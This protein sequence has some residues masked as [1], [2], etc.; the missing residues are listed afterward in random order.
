MKVTDQSRVF[1]PTGVMVA[2]GHVHAPIPPP[3]SHTH[4]ARVAKREKRKE[5]P[6]R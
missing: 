6:Q 2:T 3:R 4:T 1:T 5:R